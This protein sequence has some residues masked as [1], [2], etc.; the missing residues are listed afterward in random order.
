MGGKDRYF[1]LSRNISLLSHFLGHIMQPRKRCL[2][3]PN[4]AACPT[5]PCWPLCEGA[6]ISPIHLC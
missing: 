2:L 4:V 3:C 6:D 5:V 1:V